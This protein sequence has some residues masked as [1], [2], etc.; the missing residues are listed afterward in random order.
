MQEALCAW[1]RVAWQAD[2]VE[3][4][5]HG[6][7]VGGAIQ[8]NRRIEV[9]VVGGRMA[10]AH[11]LVL[12][13]DAPSVLA[14]SHDRTEEYRLLQAAHAAGVT[15]AEPV[16]LCTDEGPLGGAFFLMRWVGGTAEARALT[17]AAPL[18]DLVRDC[19]RELAHIHR[20][21]PG[22][23][24]LDFLADAPADPARGAVAFLRGLLDMLPDRHPALE[25]GL[26]WLDRHAPAPASVTLC[27]RDFRTGNIM[28]EDGR[29]SAVLDWEF[30]AW[31]DPAEDI[32]W[33]CAG[34][35]RFRRPDLEAGGLGSLKDLLAAYVA[36][37]GTAP[38]RTR[39]CWWQKMALARWAVIALHQAE[40]HRSGKE[41]SIE[42]ALTGHL[43]SKLELDLLMATAV[44]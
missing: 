8:D 12:R 39:I 3:V 4:V 28:A 30:A 32:G 34:C 20:I 21:R 22:A 5:D 27:H 37:G 36:A 38:E 15:V 19:G 42:L 7:L 9:R 14:M 23:A 44:E 13:L 35:W 24:G 11:D 1:L 17:A 6:R 16:A 33:F 25:W 29:L 26:A 2:C 40:R 31:S 18:P 10:G 43:V 41:R